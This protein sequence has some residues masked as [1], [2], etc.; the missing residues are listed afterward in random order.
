MRYGIDS[1]DART[2]IGRQ[3]EGAGVCV[4]EGSVSR[5]HAHL[6]YEPIKKAWSLRE[7]ATDADYQR[8]RESLPESASYRPFVRG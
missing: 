2:L 6:S 5:H 1:I 7:I 3:L 8:L 4:L